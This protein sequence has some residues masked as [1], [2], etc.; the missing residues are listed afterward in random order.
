MEPL[1]IIYQVHVRGILQGLVS[2]E[3][4]LGAGKL[5][6]L[7]LRLQCVPGVQGLRLDIGCVVWTFP[8]HLGR[9]LLDA[10]IARLLAA[11]ERGTPV[12]LVGVDAVRKGLRFF[13]CLELR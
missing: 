12:T 9:T 5:K 4:V 8:N 6:G 1:V 11:L 7:H 2:G 10:Q 3:G 13:P